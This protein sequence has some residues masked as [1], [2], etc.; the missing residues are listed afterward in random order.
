[1][2]DEAMND[3]SVEQLEHAYAPVRESFQRAARDEHSLRLLAEQFTELA[4]T[5]NAVGKDDLCRGAQQLSKLVAVAAEWARK[6]PD[7]PGVVDEIMEFIESHLGLVES[8]IDAE[9]ANPKIDMMIDLA[10]E[11][12]SDYFIM[13]E[14]SWSHELAVVPEPE[15]QTEPEIDQEPV[16]LG[17]DIAMLLQAVSDVAAPAQTDAVPPQSVP[18]ES[19]EAAQ[20]ET[21]E[22]AN[23]ENEAFHSDAPVDLAE[24]DQAARQELQLDRE[25]LDAFLDDSLRCVALMEAAALKLDSEP[26]DKESIRAFCRELHTLKGAS[27]TVGLAGIASHMHQLENSLEEAFAANTNVNPETLFETIDFVRN[28][29]ERLN[30][31]PKKSSGAQSQTTSTDPQSVETELT[32]SSD[33]TSPVASYSSSPGFSSF[34]ASDDSSIRVR[35]AHLD[36]LMD[37]LAELVVLRNRRE[38]SASEYDLLYGELSRC[39]TR[40]SYAEEQSGNLVHTSLV[41][42]V[43]KDI[44]AVARGF[45]ALQKPVANDNA[46][47]TR[48]I[49]DFRHELM[50]LRRVPVSGLFGRLQRSAR[51][52]AKTENKQVR[53]EVVGGNTG[54]EQEIQERLYESLLHVVRNCVAHGIQSPEERTRS[55]KDATGTITLEASASAQLLVIEVRDD[56]NGVNYEAVRK[57]GIEKGLLAANSQASNAELA[58]LIFHPGFSTKEKASETSGRGVGMDVVATT[59]EKMHGRIEV[60]SV[61]GKGTTIRLLIPRR[62]GIE[63]VM[64]FRCAEQ[65]YALPMQSIVIAK[66]TRDGFANLTRLFSVADDQQE[67]SNSVL[68]VKR[69]RRST[70]SDDSLIAI[71]VD[72]LLGPEEVVVR[73]LPK[74][75]QKHPLFC[76]ITLSG[77]GKQ[78]LLLESENVTDYCTPESDFDQNYTSEAASDGLRALVV[79][80]SITARKHVSKILKEYGFATIEAGD[81]VEAIETLHRSNFALVVTDLDMPRLGGL[82]LLADI[83]NGEYCNAPVVVVSSRDDQNFRQQAL[84]FG[85]CDYINKPVS[86]QLVQSRLEQLG[87]ILATCQG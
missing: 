82:E 24:A 43:S 54:L 52:A 41:G 7:D 51:D 13:A 30:P 11:A 49:R 81:G 77:S 47:I 63:H 42:E 10:N 37:M 62:T 74:M 2:N 22:P 75:L 45:R 35:A 5:A 71:V 70:D 19:N 78:V 84:E 9:E 21:V 25:L 65:L 1:M 3:E 28:E 85:A 58:N 48:F 18:T 80:D 27:A 79:D 67:K 86:K 8:R 38:N 83:Q 61:S 55:G 39:S 40:L 6:F 20:P 44:D 26:G 12:W 29:M 66:K 72:E 16:V 36:R 33:P 31:Q 53:V 56:G 4:D 68:V 60:D 87:F 15:F 59:I 50:H 73:G 76:G 69:P 23:T 14:N 64:V 32:E 46:A 57:R 34:A 17:N